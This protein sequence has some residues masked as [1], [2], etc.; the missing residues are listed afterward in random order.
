MTHHDWLNEKTPAST[1]WTGAERKAHT[2]EVKVLTP[3]LSGTSAKESSASL[4]TVNGH[5]RTQKK[6]RLTKRAYREPIRVKESYLREEIRANRVML[7]EPVSYTHLTL[8]TNRE[9]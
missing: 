2:D 7:L 5:V 9:V 4:S 3:T 8:P 6:R 1:N